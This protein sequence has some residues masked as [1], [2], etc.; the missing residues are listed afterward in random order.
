MSPGRLTVFIVDDD[1]SV[2][3]S[4]ALRLGIE[5]Y[6]TE[7]FADAESFLQSMDAGRAGCVV[8]DLK[9]PGASG[10]EL[11]A[12]LQ[13]RGIRIPVIIITAHGDVASARTA[14]QA[15]AVDFLSKPFDTAQ[16]LHALCAA[17]EREE[18]RLK[19][20]EA[21]RLDSTKLA[22]LTTREREVLERV[23]QGLHAKEI[24][25]EM[26]ISPRTV[27]VHRARIM[28]KLDARNVAELV[29]LVVRGEGQPPE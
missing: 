18:R 28:E 27:E 26:G 19:G 3:D 13:R 8:A 29:R 14:F 20:D 24:A 2:R 25:E 16:L 9:L 5:G 22:R 17:F 4:L 12:E 6:R 11:Q 1:P 15:R 21:R 10:T 23:A 7:T